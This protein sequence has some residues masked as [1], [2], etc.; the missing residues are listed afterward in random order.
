MRQPLPNF[1]TQGA[2]RTAPRL[3]LDTLGNS[4]KWAR[5][6]RYETLRPL[7]DHRFPLRATVL[8]PIRIHNAH[9]PR[10]RNVLWDETQ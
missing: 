6:V 1:C 3:Y 4:V 7:G 2:G 9:A 8:Q 5:V 10:C